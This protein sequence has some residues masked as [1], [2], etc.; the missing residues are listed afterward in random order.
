MPCDDPSEVPR[1][2][3]NSTASGQLT[4]TCT[5]GTRGLDIYN[6]WGCHWESELK[7]WRSRA[8]FLKWKIVSFSLLTH[9]LGGNKICN[10]SG[11]RGFFFFS[12][13]LYAIHLGI[14]LRSIFSFISGLAAFTL[15][16]ACIE[17]W[18]SKKSRSPY[19][20]LESTFHPGHHLCRFGFSLVGLVSSLKTI[21]PIYYN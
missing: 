5:E 17:L 16:E 13:P 10:I 18:V 20:G 7:S 4:V 9:F 11:W 6:T 2:M 14:N 19:S 1:L 3:N 8:M 12:T 21:V 15:W